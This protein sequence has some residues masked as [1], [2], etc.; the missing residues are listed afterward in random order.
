MCGL[1]RASVF[2]C[3]YVCMCYVC[4]CVCV[5]MKTHTHTHT[6]IYT[7]IH[8]CIYAKSPTHLSLTPR[9]TYMHTHINLYIHTYIHTHACMRAYINTYI[10]TKPSNTWIWFLNSEPFV[11]WNL[12][13]VQQIDERSIDTDLS[14]RCRL[15]PVF[16]QTAYI[17]DIDPNGRLLNN[18]IRSAER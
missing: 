5:Y 14:D 8:I 12:G 1:W 16:R 11:L 6:H 10:H 13:N 2:L 7:Y 3:I 9:H 4:V 18:Y 15:R 17:N